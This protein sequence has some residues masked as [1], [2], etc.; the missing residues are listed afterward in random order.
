MSFHEERGGMLALC[1]FVVVGSFFSLSRAHFCI[2][3][4]EG[5]FFFFF[6]VFER[7]FRI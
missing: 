5:F 2:R 4:M 1:V 3:G 7:T 6:G